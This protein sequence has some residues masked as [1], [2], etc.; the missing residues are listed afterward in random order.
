[1]SDVVKRKEPMPVDERFWRKATKDLDAIRILVELVLNSGDSYSRL[2]QQGLGTPPFK[3]W[4]KYSQVVQYAGYIEVKDQAE[5]MNAQQIRK[6]LTYGA[7]TS[8]ID[9]GLNVRGAMGFGLK[10][11][12]MAMKNSNIISIRNDRISEFNFVMEEGKPYI[13]PI[14]EDEEVT[15]DE[16]KKFGIPKNGTIVRGHLSQEK[17][18]KMQL[19]QVKQLLTTHFMMRRILQ[20]DDFEVLV[21]SGPLFD[22]YERLS[23]KPP[24]GRPL[25]CKSFMISYPPFGDFMINL[26]VKKAARDLSLHGD[27]KEAGLIHYHD[28]YAVVDC[29]LWGLENDPLAQ[30]FFGEVEIKNFSVFLKEEEDVIDE[31]R[32]GLNK[33]HPFV[34]RLVF[35]I[36]TRLRHIIDAER[37]SLQQEMFSLDPKSVRETLH[38]LNSIAKEEGALGKHDVLPVLTTKNM[39]FYPNYVEAFEYLERIVYLVINPLI[40]GENRRID[41][42]S[43]NGRIEVHPQEIVLSEQETGAGK[44]FFKRITVLGKEEGLKGQIGAET[45][46]CIAILGVKIVKNPMLQPS[47]GF[48]FV[49]SETKIVDRNE[50]KANLIIDKTFIGTGDSAESSVLLS[51]SNPKIS[52]PEKVELPEN[53]DICAVGPQFV[54]LQIPIVGEGASEKGKIQALY[55]DHKTEISVEVVPPFEIHGLFRSIEFVPGEGVNT[56]GYFDGDEGKIFIYYTHPLIEKYYAKNSTKNIDFLVFAADTVA[57][58]IC[59]EILK[60]KEKRGALEIMNPENKLNEMQTFFDELYFK[61]GRQLHDLLIKLIKTLKV[62]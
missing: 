32:R 20:I 45:G 27:S 46:E 44:C 62:D 34:E 17:F 33:K 18:K 1:L 12:F 50:K 2:K 11:S 29:T 53:L 36:D 35:E 38:E 51:T 19:T 30:S 7:A 9:R 37:K 41:L 42:R 16:R 52:C 55:Q 54:R 23:Y 15:E 14:R 48:A 59:W 39:T 26:S 6:S 47:G 56:I 25:L 24:I 28:D 13:I 31:K 22:T 3:I 43:D 5:G 4:V 49:P 21:G 57:R 10:D 8:G 40:V 58:L 60:K 61:R